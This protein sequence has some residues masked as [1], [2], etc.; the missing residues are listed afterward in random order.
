MPTQSLRGRSILIVEDE[1]LIALDIESSL[2]DLGAQVTTTNALE[3]AL[4]LV[5]RD[6]LSAAV[7][8]HGMGDHSSTPLYERL[9]QR[10]IP[11]LIYSVHDLSEEDCKGGV[12][13]PK[14][15]LPDALVAA[16][17]DL[18]RN[19]DVASTLTIDNAPTGRRD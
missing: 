6:D 13:L 19:C 17:E 11:F 15:A 10:G 9:S 7:L 1:P 16:V 12:L 2:V 3:Q 5:E 14:P 18:L 4:I 8:D